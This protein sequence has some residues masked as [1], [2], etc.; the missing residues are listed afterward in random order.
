MPLHAAG[1]LGTGVS[2][3][4]VRRT[5]TRWPGEEL[6]RCWAGCRVGPSTGVGT[7]DGD[8]DQVLP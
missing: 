8:G 1:A 2:S 4:C 7:F 5:I 6:H 3:R